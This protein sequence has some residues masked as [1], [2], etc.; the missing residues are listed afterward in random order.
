MCEGS[1]RCRSITGSLLLQQMPLSQERLLELPKKKA[2]V[3]KKKEVASPKKSKSKKFINKPVPLSKRAKPGKCGSIGDSVFDPDLD[4]D[5]DPKVY[6]CYS[7][8]T[9]KR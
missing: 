8:C 3:E 4:L 9:W 2:N 6:F 7:C 5:L 1:S